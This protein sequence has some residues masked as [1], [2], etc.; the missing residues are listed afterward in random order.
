MQSFCAMNVISP[1]RRYL[2]LR[3]MFFIVSVKQKKQK[4]KYEILCKSISRP[5]LALKAFFY[6]ALLKYAWILTAKFFH[7]L[8]LYYVQH[9][10]LKETFV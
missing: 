4:K 5:L 10:T 3:R 8:L 9:N 1:N 7:S 6:K 2:R